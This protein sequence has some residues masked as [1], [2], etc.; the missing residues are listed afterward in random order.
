M[1]MCLLSIVESATVQ[2][3]GGWRTLGRSDT[4]KVLRCLAA[5][6]R[7]CVSSCDAAMQTRG[8]RHASVYLVKVATVKVVVVAVV[9]EFGLVK[10]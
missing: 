7:R 5:G 2:D 3:S 9:A 10:G 4:D 6:W 8:E 1:S